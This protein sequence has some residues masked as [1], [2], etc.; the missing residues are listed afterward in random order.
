MD[1]FHFL[2][3]GTLKDPFENVF[4]YIRRKILGVIE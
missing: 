3:K 1:F 2:S 4:E